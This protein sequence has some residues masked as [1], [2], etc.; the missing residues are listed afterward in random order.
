M[1]LYTAYAGT[2]VTSTASAANNML[3]GPNGSGN[4]D[5]D[6]SWTATLGGFTFPV[7]AVTDGGYVQIGFT[8]RRAGGNNTPLLSWVL[9]DSLGTVL[10]SGAPGAV[11]QLSYTTVFATGT[12]VN[13]PAGVDMSG[14]TLE[15]TVDNGGGSPSKRASVQVDAVQ[16]RVNGT[17]PSPPTT[18]GALSVTSTGATSVGL[19]WGAATGQTGYRVEWSTDNTFATKSS[20]TVGSGVTTY[21]VPSLTPGTLYYFRVYATNGSGDSSPSNTASTTTTAGKT[22][23]WWSGSAWLDKPLYRWD[24]SALVPVTSLKYWNGSSWVETP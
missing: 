15:L 2:V 23:K 6:T 22:V 19:S 13:L 7:G 17:L 20:A 16:V 4:L 9:K 10:S 18:P 14:W 24:G 8:Y 12:P 3:N 11:T 1:T 21:T 5:T